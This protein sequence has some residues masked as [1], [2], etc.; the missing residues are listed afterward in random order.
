MHLKLQL[1]LKIFLPLI[2][3]LTVTACSSMYVNQDPTGMQFPSIKGTSLDNKKYQIPE[4]LSDQKTLLL[5]GYKQKS[6]FDIDRWMIGIDMTIE[7]INL[8]E[9]PTIQGFFP[10]LFQSRIDKGMRSGIPQEL[11]PVVITVYEDGSR[12]QSFT[13][14]EK[15]NN[16]R[17][18]LLNEQGKVIYFHDNGFSVKALND[19]QSVLEK[20]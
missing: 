1:S 10:T 8:I 12:V 5:I 14:N 7:D 18:L 4:D 11:W 9:L 16:A 19:L 20:T 17:V 6:Q 15:P 3:L 13:G 2:V